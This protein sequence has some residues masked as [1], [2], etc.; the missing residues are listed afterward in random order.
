MP[1]RRLLSYS[2]TCQDSKK[3]STS[4]QIVHHGGLI[5]QRSRTSSHSCNK[6]CYYLSCVPDNAKL[7]NF[8]FSP[9][10]FGQHARQLKPFSDIQGPENIIRSLGDHP[11][12]IHTTSTLPPTTKQLAALLYFAPR[13]LV[14]FPC[15]YIGYIRGPAEFLLCQV[16]LKWLHSSSCVRISFF[17]RLGRLQHGVL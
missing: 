12:Y 16:T 6:H 17:L 14:S 8:P 13:G 15:R 11:N 9:Q 4:S 3:P 1:H 2:F 10:V 7:L 5:F